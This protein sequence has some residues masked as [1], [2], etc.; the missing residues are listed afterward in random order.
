MATAA[1][2]GTGG[3]PHV[4]A[5]ELL[6]GAL[7]TIPADLADGA[8]EEGRMGRDMGPMAC[9]AAVVVLGRHVGGFLGQLIA[10]FCV[11]ARTQG[12]GGGSEKTRASRCMWLMAGDA[13]TILEGSMPGSAIGY[14]EVEIVALPAH[15][16]LR[17]GK[18]A[19][20]R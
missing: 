20:Y 1:V 6:R 13:V 8:D 17:G 11:A 5:P 16:G 3:Q 10:D 2:H 14:G 18:K 12:A 9:Q 19:L 15:R 4:S 7:V